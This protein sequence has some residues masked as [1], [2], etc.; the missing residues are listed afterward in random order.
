MTEWTVLRHA[1]EGDTYRLEVGRDLDEEGRPAE[2]RGFAWPADL[3]EWDGLEPAE[4]AEA[5]RDQARA[6]LEA[7]EAG[8]AEPA[9]DLEAEA[10]EAVE[11]LPGVGEAL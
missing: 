5:Q 10:D 2:V 1:L 9:G 7:E 6:T 3:P 8:E 11:E 4:V